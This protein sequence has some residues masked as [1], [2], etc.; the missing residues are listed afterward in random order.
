MQN[1]KILRNA[2]HDREM[3]VS[4]IKDSKPELPR[5]DTWFGATVTSEFM[6]E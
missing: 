1:I 6:G 4:S 5:D 2:K 3:E